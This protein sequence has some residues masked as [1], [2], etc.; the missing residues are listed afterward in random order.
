MTKGGPRWGGDRSR[1]V[2]DL[3]D[4]MKISVTST[5]VFMEAAG[6]VGCSSAV[7]LEDRKSEAVVRRVE[8][9]RAGFRKIES[10]DLKLKVRRSCGQ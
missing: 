6:A 2:S 7:R 8:R 10:S 5:C 4:H 1:S 3:R 9:P